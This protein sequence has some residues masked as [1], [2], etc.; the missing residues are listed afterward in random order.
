MAAAWP[1]LDSHCKNLFCVEGGVAFLSMGEWFAIQVMPRSEQKV[2][3]YLE[4]KGYETLLPTYK[5]KRKWADRIKL[6]ELPLFPDYIFFRAL[7]TNS[8]MVLTIP[9]TVRLLGMGGRPSVIP[10]EEIESLRKINTSRVPA[11]PCRY[12][13]IGQKVCISVGPLAG[14]VGL[15]SEV[16]NS[17]RLIVTVELIMRSISVDVGVSEVTLAP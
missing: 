14:I 10:A 4:Y 7:T 11:A 2:V 1:L 16:K 5:C 9:G 17:R 8:G 12:I 3:Q 15:L 13:T 6:I